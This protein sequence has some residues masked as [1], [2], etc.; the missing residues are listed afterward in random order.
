MDSN[1][2]EAVICINIVKEAIAVDNKQKALKFLGI[3]R[4]LNQN[5]PID[6]LLSTCENLDPSSSSSNPSNGVKKNVPDEKDEEASVNRDRFLNGE[7]S[8][9]EE[10]VHMAW[11]RIAP[12]M[13]S[14]RHT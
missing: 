9:T 1:K 13:K 4:R 14:G 8:Y 7:R 6:D 3:T 10:H 5:L 2:D 12:W 11:K